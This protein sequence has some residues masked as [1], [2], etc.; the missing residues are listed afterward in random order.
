M[1]NSI[2]HPEVQ[3]YIDEHLNSD[4]SKI[5]FKGTNFQSVSTP[6]VVE[7]I[8]AKKKSKEKLPTWFSTKNIYYP[9]KLNIEQTSSETTAKYKSDLISGS[10]IIDLTGGFGVDSYYFS[11]KA[12]QVVH[13][14]IN[15][16]LS[17]IA[18]HNFK[19]LEASNIETIAE[20][21]IDYLM[22]SDQNFDCIYID[23]SRRNDAKGKVFLL[24]DCLPNVPENIEFL[25]EKSTVILIKNSPILDI[26]SA[27]NELKYVKEIH[28]V[29]V[30]NEVK[31]L[32]YILEKNYKNSIE[33]KTINILKNKNQLFDFKLDTDKNSTFSLVKKY[34]Y[35]PN[36]SIM[37]SGGFNEVSAQLKIDKLHQNSHLY[38]SEKLIDFPGRR[39]EVSHTIPFDKKQLKKLIPSGKANITTR[40]FPQTVAQIRKKTGLKDGGEIYLFFTTDINNKHLVIVCQ[41]IIS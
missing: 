41:K 37:K 6:E 11:K 23:P 16:N 22:K 28:V 34:V 35:E 33:I 2:L 19:L 38:T 10:S 40:N 26:T 17:E 3:N 14:E 36:A 24:K 13:C 5:L 25:F 31:E 7:Q 29:A 27:I 9:N 30:H 15:K 18:S 8:A 21:G 39:F 4:V 12:S 32:L 20:N 1:N